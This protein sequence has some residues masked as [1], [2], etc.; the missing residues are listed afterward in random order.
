MPVSS[1]SHSERD[2]DSGSFSPGNGPVDP[3]VATS[4]VVGETVR[5]SVGGA[6][7]RVLIDSETVSRSST[8]PSPS[9][10]PSRNR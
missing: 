4:A 3:A 1:A 10:D 7:T 8:A 6:G 5:D 2:R 9:A